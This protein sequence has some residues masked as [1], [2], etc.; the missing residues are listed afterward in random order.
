[1]RQLKNLSNN[2]RNYYD[3]NFSKNIITKR[4]LELLSL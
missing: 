2:S 4:I 3:N 1:M